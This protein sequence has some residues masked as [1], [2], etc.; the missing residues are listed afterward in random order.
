MEIQQHVHQVEQNIEHAHVEQVIVE[1]QVHWDIA[2]MVMDYVVVA[3]YM[4]LA[5]VRL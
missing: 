2:Q 4:F 1:E 3:T 5:K